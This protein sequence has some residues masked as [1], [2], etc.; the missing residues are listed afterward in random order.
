MVAYKAY[1][2][3]LYPNA[4]QKAYFAKAFGAVRFLWNQMLANR[5]ELYE[6]Y[7]H[8]KA[9]LK[10]HKPKS[11]TQFKHEFEWMYETDNN[12][13]ANVAL[14]INSA[15]NNFFR[16]VKKGEKPGFPKF[17]SK[18]SGKNSYTTCMF[19]NNI[20]IDGGRI[21]IPKAGFVK[22]A[23]HRE[24]PDTFV[25]KSATISLAPSGKYFVSILTEHE[26][27]P[28]TPV[29]DKSKALGL[30]YSSPSFYVDSQGNE[31][32]YPKFYRQIEERLA[33]E[34]RKLSKMVPGSQN[35]KKQKIRVA[36]VHERLSNQR[37]DWSHKRST[38]LA[39]TWDYI[40]VEDINLR[41]MAGSLKLGKATN[42]NGFGAFRE[43]LAYKMDERGKE[44]VKIGKW[45]PSS[46][47]C[48]EC[49]QINK[50]LTLGDREWAC[51]C[52][53][54]HDRD[55]NAAINIRDCGLQLATK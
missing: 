41:G 32:G 18:R 49:G 22:M 31:A 23:Q 5:I 27:E 54:Y 21:R 35:Y 7:G 52:G 14:N 36:K 4:E 47:A 48:N 37:K 10:E 8:D 2:F 26:W 28:P 1:K 43:Y 15:Y 42:D 11:Y 45:F 34:Q 55:T 17:K 29:L 9:L 50:S 6:K 39:N 38:E 24:I 44:F 40:C 25:I 16:R 51:D 12:A 19:G 33:I 30:D 53:A 3:R 46:K 13:L 20:R